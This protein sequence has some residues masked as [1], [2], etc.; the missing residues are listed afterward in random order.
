MPIG[1]TPALH[2]HGFVVAALAKLS[3]TLEHSRS[4]SLGERR[5][6]CPVGD[7]A[8]SDVAPEERHVRLREV[9]LEVT[10]NALREGAHKDAAVAPVNDLFDRN[11][12]C[13]VL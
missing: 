5:D 11:R 3:W 7:D 6:Q 12:F 10:R 9:Q 1:K 2:S 4:S 8:Q 13:F